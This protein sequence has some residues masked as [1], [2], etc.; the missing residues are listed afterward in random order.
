V[1]PTPPRLHVL[2]AAA[3]PVAV[4]FRRGPTRWAH[5]V[6]LDLDA[7]T[8]EHGAWLRGRLFP[9]RSALSADGRLLGYVAHT[10][11][12]PPW[13]V[14]VAISR[15]PW[16][17]ALAAWHALTTYV[18]G[19]A[20]DLDGSFSHDARELIAGA[21]PRR[22]CRSGPSFPPTCRAGSAGGSAT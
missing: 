20:F 12:R 7:A 5:V 4:V 1:S 18:E 22:F 3:A 6:K 11:R 15:P 14:Y 16:L 9:R 2:T 19:S 17:T 10:A 13:D 8:V 21:F